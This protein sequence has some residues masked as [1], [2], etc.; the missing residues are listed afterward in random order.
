MCLSF[1]GHLEIHV[2]WRRE[3]A[4]AFSLFHEVTVTGPREMVG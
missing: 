3:V 2:H 4:E 1:V